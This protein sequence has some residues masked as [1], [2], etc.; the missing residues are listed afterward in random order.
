[1]LGGFWIVLGSVL[2]QFWIDVGS[3]WDRFGI[4][5]GSPGAS[6][7]TIPPN[8]PQILKVSQINDFA[9]KSKVFAFLGAKALDLCAKP[10][11]LDT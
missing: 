2:G 1:M 9:L 6:S 3:V 10:F 11:D 7:P 8:V 5:L 4:R